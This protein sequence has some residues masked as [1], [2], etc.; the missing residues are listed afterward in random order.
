MMEK[1]LTFNAFF[2]SPFILMNCGNVFHTKSLCLYCAMMEALN[3]RQ[4]MSLKTSSL[5]YL[6]EQTATRNVG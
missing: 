3:F 6:Y 4:V 2:H 5:Y 1:H